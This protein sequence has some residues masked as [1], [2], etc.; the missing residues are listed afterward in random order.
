MTAHLKGRLTLTYSSYRIKVPG[1]LLIAGEY[2]VLEPNQQ[3]VVI[4]VNRYISAYIEPSEQN[5]LSLPQLGFLNV[6]WEMNTEDVQFNVSDPQLNFIRNSISVVKKYLSESSVKFQ[7]FHLTIKSELD[8]PAT[9][10][11]YGLGSSAAVVVSVVSAILMLHS[12]EKIRPTLEQVY[13]LSAIAHLKTQKNGSG[14]DIAAS[15]FGGWLCYSSLQPNWVLNELQ[16]ENTLTALMAKPWPNLS[17]TPLTAP[18][19]LQLCVGWTGEAAK[20][21][22]MIEKVEQF[23]STNLESYN[24]FLKRNCSAVN[25][26]L[27]SFEL[28]DCIGAISSLTQNR[29]ALM[30]LSEQA[31]ITIETSKLKN[32]SQL[33]E[34]MGSGKSSG[35]G[36]GDC[37]IAFVK[38][39]GY[40]EELH[41]AWKNAGII[42]LN[43]CVSEEGVS[44][45]EYNCDESMN[46]YYGSKTSE[47]EINVS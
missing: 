26:L 5:L 8:D 30:M 23:R 27:K 33:A 36:G 39:D 13:K 35:A 21:G 40:I 45:T 32:L 25:Q 17:I 20:T 34:K 37:G 31:D 18:S 2:A 44:V 47:Q 10:K 1:K 19:N 15:T 42:P 4:A 11:K 43:L 46:E 7:P 38:G 14:V 16:Q 22:P 12:G 3:A 6:T 29:K 41:K 28:N 24:E 9:G